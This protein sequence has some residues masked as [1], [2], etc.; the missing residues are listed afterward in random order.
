MAWHWL[1]CSTS[2][3]FFCSSWQQSLRL[4]LDVCHVG[5]CSLR[6]CVGHV[7]LAFWQVIATVLDVV[8][9]A[10]LNEWRVRS[11]IDLVLHGRMFTHALCSEWTLQEIPWEPKLD[12]CA[13]GPFVFIFLQFLPLPLTPGW[14]GVAGAWC[15]YLCHIWS[16]C[17]FWP[18]V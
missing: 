11:F 13:G 14:T 1:V 5:C 12:E 6:S 7:H 15:G 10:W 18:L 17:W 2:G 16:F 4:L 9:L 3:L 8:C